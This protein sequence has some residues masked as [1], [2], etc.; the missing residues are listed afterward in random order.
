[1]PNIDP[2]A[3]RTALVALLLVAGAVLVRSRV[4]A[5]PV[6]PGAAAGPALGTTWVP[7]WP[8][9]STISALVALLSWQTVRRARRRRRREPEPVFET[10]APLK[11]P[12]WVT[13]LMVVPL[14]VPWLLWILVGHVG[15]PT[16]GPAA[17]AHR[18]PGPLP[19]PGHVAPGASAPPD[20]S[21]WAVVGVA[22]LLLLL[23]LALASFRRSRPAGS[24]GGSQGDPA[25]VPPEGDPEVV[26]VALA[27][28]AVHGAGPDRHR[29]IKAFAAMEEAL[30]AEGAG[31]HVS[32]TPDELLSRVSRLHPGV[33]EQAD[34]L[35]DVFQLARFSSNPV[36]PQHVDAATAA[37]GRLE[38]ALGVGHGERV[39]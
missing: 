31:R 37:L 8:V 16:A 28:Q 11:S 14:S 10:P 2:R 38:D 19:S 9:V 18:P 35:T 30:A 5:A 25:L 13:L 12:W 36:T 17:P 39:R 34:R 15:L 1:M 20:P 33:T 27:R 21:V 7:L 24:P 32:E 4:P 23:L 6:H 22:A 29:I 3:V 26:A